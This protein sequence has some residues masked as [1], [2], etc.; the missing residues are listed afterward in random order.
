MIDIWL[1]VCVRSRKGLRKDVSCRESLGPKNDEQ[2]LL[3]H[4]IKLYCSILYYI[5]LYNLFCPCV[6]GEDVELKCDYDLQGDKL[7]S[8]KWYRYSYIDLQGD[9]IYSVK[10]YR[11][12]YVI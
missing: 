9:K 1:R 12:I 6:Q 3:Y 7:Y 10:W 5:L 4:I 8:V 11:Y 2:L